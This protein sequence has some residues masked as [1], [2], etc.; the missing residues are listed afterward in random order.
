MKKF[1][2][3]MS[4]LWDII[5]EPVFSVIIFIFTVSMYISAF[6]LGRYTF[7]RYPEAMSVVIMV[8]LA[9]LVIGLIIMGWFKLSEIY[10]RFKKEWELRKE[11]IEE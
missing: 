11:K 7:E 2:L 9:F 8:C 3:F 5:A 1:K 10:R 4:I 6:F